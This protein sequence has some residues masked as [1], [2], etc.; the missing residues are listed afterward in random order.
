M[1]CY[2]RSVIRV[3]FYLVYFISSEN[4]S[5]FILWITPK[6]D[7]KKALNEKVIFIGISANI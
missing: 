5:N 3:G 2:M 6:D 1:S 7:L 4:D